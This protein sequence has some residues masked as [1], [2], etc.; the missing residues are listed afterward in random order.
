LIRVIRVPFHHTKKNPRLSAARQ[1]NPF[2]PRHPRSFSPHQKKSA[3][4]RSIRVIRVPFPQLPLKQ[5]IFEKK[6]NNDPQTS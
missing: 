1:A 5:C 6:L 2:D 4:I 3:P